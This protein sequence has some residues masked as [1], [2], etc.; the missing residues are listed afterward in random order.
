MNPMKIKELKEGWLV[1]LATILQFLVGYP[2]NLLPVCGVLFVPKEKAFGASGTERAIIIGLFTVFMNLVS[3][4][5]GPLV[6]AKGHRYVAILATS[7]QVV[8][9]VICAFSGSIT[10]LM[11]GFGVFVGMG[12]GLALVNNII[13]T[14]KTFPNSVGIAVGTALTCICLTGLLIPQ[15]LQALT[16]YFTEHGDTHNQWTIF[17]YALMGCVG[18]FGAVLMTSES[19]NEEATPVDI[20]AQEHQSGLRYIFK[21]FTTLLKDSNYILTALANSCCFSIMVYFISLLGPIATSRDFEDSSSNFVTIF[22]AVNSLTLL[23]MGFLGDSTIMGRLFKY[24]KKCLYIACC[25]GMMLTFFFFSVAHSFTSLVVGTVMLAIFTSGMF[26]TT[27]LVYCDCFPTKFDSAVG[28]SNLFRCFFA[29]SINPLAGYFEKVKGCEDLH[30]TFQFLT[31]TTFLLL[32][33]WI[34]LPFLIKLRK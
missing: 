27:N 30:Y 34:L 19:G 11:I 7:S 5:V 29:L 12:V 3:I 24:P 25:I 2:A 26:I 10:I 21:E 16:E 18:Y 1:I 6:K 20:E 33:L 13:I 32:M 8:G 9:L 23:P 15:I 4:F 14:K 28:L 31:C 17:S 22:C